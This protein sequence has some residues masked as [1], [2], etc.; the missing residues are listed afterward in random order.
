MA[1]LIDGQ[2]IIN[3]SSM[4]PLPFDIRRTELMASGKLRVQI[5][6]EKRML[7]LGWSLIKD[8]DLKQIL[9]L[10]S[11]KAFHTVTY[12]DPQHGE[13]HTITAVVDGNIQISSWRTIGGVRY[14]QDVSISLREQ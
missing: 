6:A 9:D 12:P 14:W 3:P 5:I 8:T 11:A 1:V 13:D 10:L 7:H 4:Q 2:E